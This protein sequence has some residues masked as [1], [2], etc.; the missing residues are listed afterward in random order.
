MPDKLKAKL[1]A[2]GR[3]KDLIEV[4]IRVRHTHAMKPDSERYMEKLDDAENFAQEVERELTWEAE[5][6]GVAIEVNWY[7]L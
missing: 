2:R 6:N 7:Y 4:R 5:R 1:D 3:T